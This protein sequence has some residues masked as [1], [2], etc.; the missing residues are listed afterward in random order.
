MMLLPEENDNLRPMIDGCNRPDPEEKLM[1]N[2]RRGLSLAAL[3]L[4]FGTTAGSAVAQGFPDK[5]INLTIP[6]APGGGTDLIGRAIGKGMSEALNTPVIILNKA[7]N[8]TILG[9]EAVARSAPDGYNLV[10]ATIAHSVNPSLRAT[11]PYDTKAAFE[12]VT[13]IASSHNVLVVPAASP[14]KSVADVIAKAKA[15][16]GSLSYASQ[17]PGTSAHLAG[18]LFKNI[19]GVDIKHVP[20]RG[21]GPALADVLGGH[22]DMMFATRAAA[23]AYVDAGTMRALGITSPAGQSTMKN[24]PSIADEGLAGYVVDSWYGLYAPAGTPKAVIEKLNA[25]VK[26]AVLSPEFVRLA[27]N[28][29]LVVRA[30][31]PEELAAFVAADMVRWRKIVQENKI[32]VD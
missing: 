24:V 20:Y 6:F 7:G 31:P 21:A 11:M 9:S 17:G 12:P 13:M 30:G 1:V 10:V 16:P 4:I 22:V 5:A 26:K 15:A 14:L 32:T 8:S 3:L 23:T 2:P 25:A 29:G 18:E 28:E 27:N 19:S